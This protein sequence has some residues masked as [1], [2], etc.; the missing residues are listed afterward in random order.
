MA[1]GE[2]SGSEGYGSTTDEIIRDTVIDNSV[3]CYY[4]AV[5]PLFFF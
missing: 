1:E 2:S 3:R 5:R 4:F